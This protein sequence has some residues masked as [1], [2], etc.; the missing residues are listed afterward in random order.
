MYINTI[1]I[2]KNEHDLDVVYHLINWG[3][4]KYTHDGISYPPLSTGFPQ[5]QYMI[6]F[7]I[8]WFGIVIWISKLPLSLQ[9]SRNKYKYTALQ[10]IF[11]PGPGRWLSS[12]L[13]Y[14][15]AVFSVSFVLFSYFGSQTIP[16]IFC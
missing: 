4:Y 8:S 16:V 5:L 2:R 15:V 6:G 12:L 14:P 10:I 3:K 13:T 1:T 9:P 7:I 11:Y